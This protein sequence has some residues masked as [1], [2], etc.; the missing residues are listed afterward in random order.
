LNNFYSLTDT[1]TSKLLEPKPHLQQQQQQQQQQCN[2]LKTTS[3]AVISKEKK[4]SSLPTKSGSKTNPLNVQSIITT[5]KRKQQHEQQQQ[6]QQQQHLSL[7]AKDETSS[8]PSQHSLSTHANLQQPP[9]AS[10]YSTHLSS[11]SSA[12]AECNEKILK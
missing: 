1:K 3:P 8:T 9:H 12:I 5:T 11:N 7:I 6:Q 2:G 4:K 10:I